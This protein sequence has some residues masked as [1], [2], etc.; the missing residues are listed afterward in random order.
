MRLATIFTIATLFTVVWALAAFGAIHLGIVLYGLWGI[1]G[2]VIAYALV[3]WV[4]TLI[5]GFTRG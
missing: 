3:L 1:K 5:V 2:V 4:L